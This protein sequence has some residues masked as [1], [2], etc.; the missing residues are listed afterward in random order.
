MI[1]SPTGGGYKLTDK[2]DTNYNF[3]TVPATGGPFTLGGV[4]IGPLTSITDAYGNSLTVTRNTAGEVT[5]LTSASGR[6]LHVTWSTPAGAAY[7]H[8]ATVATDPVTP[9][10]SATALTWTYSYTGDQ[11]SKVCS[12]GSHCTTYNYTTGSDY[13]EAVL[14]TSPHSYWRLGEASGPTAVS[15]ELVNEGADN[16]TYSGVALGQPGPLTGSPATSAG[17]NGTSS[18]LQL[19]ASLA[20]GADVQ[21]MSMWFKTSTAGGVLLSAQSSPI[22]GAQSGSYTPELYV[23]SDGKLRGEYYDGSVAPI[24]SAAA[25][26]DGKWHLVLITASGTTQT[27][28]LDG[29]AVGSLSGTVSN[30]VL[31][32]TY[33]G[34]GYN[35]GTWP[36]E[37]YYSTTSSTGTASYFNGDISDVA[38]WDKA[39]TA[40]QVTGLYAAGT[41]QGSWL[42]KVTRPTGSVYAQASY[43][44]VTGMLSAVTDS[45]GGQWTMGGTAVTGS[46]QEYAGTVLAADPADYY[47]LADTGTS[48]ATDQVRG[49]TAAYNSVTEGVAGPFPDDTAD[50]FNG[51]SS[52]LALPS[53][54]QVITG[55]GSI[56]L[57]FQ[58]TG[59]N[60]VLYSADAVAAGASS[61]T[62]GYQPS[63]YVGS[64]GKLIGRFSN[65]YPA[66][67]I[68]SASPVNDGRW[69]F[70]V[71]SASTSS[72]TMYLDGTAVGT[73]AGTLTNSGATSYVYLGTGY[74]GG[75]WPDESHSGSGTGYP[76]YF[77][78]SMAEFAAFRSQLT[79]DQ[80]AGQWAAAKKSQGLTPVQTV[81]VTDPGGK[82]LSWSY[83]PLNG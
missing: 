3:G 9:G 53:Q 21:S 69:H 76:S 11:L 36:A 46:S 19:P 5:Q 39:I 41:T 62:A 12:P 51:T 14:D 29:A 18:Y 50:A 59:S 24:T 2:N 1:S 13:P 17:F 82:T 65:S 44:G 66:E 40:S 72:Q 27:L 68:T 83:D 31:P 20:S 52:Y 57:W 78:G 70:V 75:S 23:G 73:N 34:A 64:D 54:D 28:Y 4:R 43:N 30:T 61:T 6:A 63:L 33:V 60:E 74:L 47:R 67:V 71:L 16:A 35:G 26:D 22:T 10:N 81:Q 42:T 55:P 8:V 58:T 56:E 45:N 37:P 80:V 25:V 79:A 15:S 38:F 48:T 32:D 77:T 49:G 7:P